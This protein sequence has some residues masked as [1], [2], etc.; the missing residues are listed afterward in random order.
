M[1][2]KKPSSTIV[3]TG[4]LVGLG[5]VYDSSGR[6]VLLPSESVLVET[7]GWDMEVCLGWR[8]FLPQIIFEGFNGPVSSTLYV[9]TE[10]VVLI[11]D[12]DVWRET[13]ADM[14]PLGIPGGVAK[15]VDLKRLAS[16]GAREFCE[17]RPR[18]MQVAG[19]RRLKKLQAWLDFH[20]VGS[21]GQRYEVLL[22]KIGGE[23]VETATLLESRFGNHPRPT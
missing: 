23:D 4:D 10:R 18:Q 12:I 11:R 20:L 9:T 17:L 7:K 1:T 2:K 5:T 16:A 19:L 13:K 14:S 3:R 21:D 22:C 15:A 8:R 6:L